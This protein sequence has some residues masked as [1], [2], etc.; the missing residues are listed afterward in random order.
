MDLYAATHGFRTV[1]LAVGLEDGPHTA[2]VFVLGMHRPASRGSAI[3]IDR[4]IVR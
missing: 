1:D 2:V 3:G 4:W